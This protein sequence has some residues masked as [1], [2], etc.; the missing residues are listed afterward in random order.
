MEIIKKLSKMISEEIA[1]AEKYAKCALKHKSDMPELARAFDNL[2]RQ[3]MEH[4][5]MLHTAAVGIIE[6]Y[7]RKN[8]DPPPAMQAVYDYLHEEQI[9][10]AAEVRRLQDMFR[11]S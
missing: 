2:S 8:G 11:E 7:R 4:S 9:E 10:Q 5:K 1:D 6:E 3:E